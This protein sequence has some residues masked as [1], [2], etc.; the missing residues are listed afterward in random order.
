MASRTIRGGRTRH[1][2]FLVIS[3]LGLWF[4]PVLQAATISVTT[5]TDE[6][7]GAGG[8]GA[9]CAL[10]EAIDSVN[11]ATDRGGCSSAGA[12]GSGDTINV[13]AGTYTLSL[14]SQLTLSKSVIIQSTSANGAKD[15][16]IQANA[17]AGTAT[18]RVFDVVG[19]GGS[20]NV[21][22]QDLTIRNGNETTDGGGGIR[23][24]SVVGGSLT[25]TGCQLS[26]NQAANNGGGLHL[27]STTS[28]CT[29]TITGSTFDNNVSMTASSGGGGALSDAGV[30]NV[31]SITNCTFVGNSAQ[32]S[33]GAIRAG[34]TG[35]AVMTI[36]NV[37]ITTS[38][39][40]SDNTGG[41]SGGGIAQV[42]GIVNVSNT[43][44]AQNSV[45]SSGAGPDCSAAAA[46]SVVSKGFDF[47]GIG[48][49]GGC[50]G[51]VNASNGDQVGTSGSPLNANL[52]PL[53]DYGGTTLTTGPNNVT[54]LP[55]NAG[56][57]GSIVGT[58]PCA[59]TDQRGNVRPQGN[60]LRCD[61]GSLELAYCGDG[62]VCS[63]AACR[64]TNEPEACDDGALNG[65]AGS[66]CTSTCQVEADN[67]PCSADGDG[68]TQNDSC[69]SGTCT[70]GSLVSCDDSLSCTTD[71]CISTGD[72][73]FTCS[74]T[75]DAGACLIGGTCYNAAD[76]NPGNQCQAC[77]PA[78]SQTA[79]SD[80]TDGTLCNFDGDGC[81][82]NDSCQSGTCTVGTT[83]TCDDGFTCTT[84]TC[85]S[86]GDNT[87][88]C[89]NP[90]NSGTC[91]IGGSCYNDGDA[92]P[93]N[94]CQQCS[95]GTSQT[96]FSNKS[97]GTSCNADS[98]GCTADDSCQSGSCSAG[99]FP[100]DCV[101][102]IACTDDQCSSTGNNTHTCSNPI[103]AGTC[104]I[105][106]TCYNNGQNNPSNDCQA[107]LTGTSQSSFSNKTDGT[108]CNF[109]SDGCTQNDS[110]QTGSCTVGTTVTCDD[111]LSCTTDT[112]N[113]TGNNAHTCA[114]T[115]DSGTCLIGGSCYNDGDS[116]DDCQQCSSATSQ[117]QFSIKDADGDA[118]CDAIEKAGPNGGD[119][120]GDGSAD[121]TEPNVGSLPCANGNGYCTVVASGTDTGCSD[122]K[123][124]DAVLPPTDPS[125]AYPFGMVTFKLNCSTSAPIKAYYSAGGNL[126]QSLVYRK[127]GLV[128]PLFLGP[129]QLYTF[130]PVT[131]ATELVPPVTG[132]SVLTASFTLTDNAFGD[133]SPMA[134]MILD[135]GGPALQVRSA[136]PTLS[137]W[138]LVALVTLLG[139]V[140]GF[141]LS[142]RRAPRP[143]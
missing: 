134:G 90:V 108:L 110:C 49:S 33:G 74:N 30:D 130:S 3:V 128:A 91:L 131:F 96:S 24:E 95:A 18:Y 129:P 12:Y 6:N 73:S 50:T 100:S 67:F 48:D 87:H 60:P 28:G 121:Y 32:D 99:S 41:G 136:A 66:C 15:T 86:T 61:I 26:H 62:V 127:F 23:L 25:I 29:A 59:A 89:S 1:A 137:P 78:T 51:F 43:I 58:T 53:G 69:Q 124:V 38:T 20:L 64:G 97:N 142:R 139:A 76:E 113:S 83:I 70:A 122:L 111:G 106:G 138:G 65:T 82:Q 119:A 7:D 57:D 22:F 42:S 68:C 123:N 35:S 37:T 17:S 120:N 102:G 56:N 9:G 11:M 140:A 36:N 105:G 54:D 109:D 93:G 52:A 107:C 112:C 126:M 27:R 14:G 143:E 101:D 133:G 117:T 81:T 8:P 47:I 115:I 55:I 44:L 94:Q 72:N 39:A 104:L 34:G 71:S 31:L 21:G 80:K 135:P 4:V 5:T 77:I 98:N 46:A 19:G 84:D 118:V 103:S 141:G 88:T 92:N 132:T 40:D 85:N 125:Y 79:F 2:A 63:G 13:P 75:I 116:P 45:G 10:R 16:V 114:N